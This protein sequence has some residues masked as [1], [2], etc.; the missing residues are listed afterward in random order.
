MTRSHS[1]VCKDV[2]QL[3]LDEAPQPYEDEVEETTDFVDDMGYDSVS[4]VQLGFAVEQHFDLDPIT[5]ED[6]ENVRN[7]G[8]LVRFVMARSGKQPS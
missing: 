4:L 1:E 5:R 8:D 2:F 6:V 7:A 3:L